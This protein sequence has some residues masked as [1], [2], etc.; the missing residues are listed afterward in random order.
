MVDALPVKGPR[1]LTRR[2]LLLSAGGAAIGLGL[3]ACAPS[4]P[5]PSKPAAPAA[6]TAPAAAKPAEK[7]AA[8]KP[9]ASTTVVDRPVRSSDPNPKRGGEVRMAQNGTAAH[10]DLAQGSSAPTYRLYSK[11][12]QKDPADGY[13]TLI[14]D[15]AK[16]VEI[17]SD[18]KT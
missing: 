17:A 15:L 16:G 10:F 1:K 6:T 14:T 5:A 3:A 18:N 11:L 12:L 13:K 2:T 7:P 9:V 4:A 8:D